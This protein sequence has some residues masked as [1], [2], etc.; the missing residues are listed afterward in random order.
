MSAPKTT[1]NIFDAKVL[2]RILSQVA[3]YRR[4]FL[5]TGLLVFVLAG[6]SWVRPY[7]IRLALDDHIANGDGEGLLRIF[8]WVVGLIVV[9]ALLQFWQT[10]W[11]NWVAQSVTLDLRSALFRHVSRFRLKYFDQTPVGQLVTRHI[12]DVDGIADVFSNGL[13]NAVGDILKLAVVV[14]A[15]LWIDVR[16]T[17]FVCCRFR[18]CLWPHGSFKRPLKRRL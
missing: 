6:I 12:S 15:M 14:G 2:R 17:L 4:R 8:L 18:F 11:A 5:L 9:E 3:P 1:G 16:L 13:L 7:L 10:Y